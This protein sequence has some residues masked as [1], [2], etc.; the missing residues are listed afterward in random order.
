YAEYASLLYFHYIGGLVLLA[1]SHRNRQQDVIVLAAEFLCAGIQVDIDLRL[2]I[3]RKGVRPF[4]HFDGRIPYI[5]LLHHHLW[6]GRLVAIGCRT[7]VL[8]RHEL[9]P[10]IIRELVGSISVS[11]ACHPPASH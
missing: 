10:K 11:P 4:R 1:R 3:L 8:I 2:V 6:L 7:A 5:D 9:S